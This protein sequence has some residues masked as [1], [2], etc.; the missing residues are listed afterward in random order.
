MCVSCVAPEAIS[1]VALL[2]VQGHKP[3]RDVG[4]KYPEILEAHFNAI[5]AICECDWPGA[6]AAQ[7]TALT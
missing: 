4:G 6:Y 1:A 7:C 2:L 3:F 5:L